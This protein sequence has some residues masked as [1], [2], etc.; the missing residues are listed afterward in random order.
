MVRAVD[1]VTDGRIDWETA[2]AGGA[3]AA[4][5]LPPLPAS[6][7]DSIRRNKIAIKGP[8]STPI[9]KGLRTVNVA[10]RQEL[11]LYASVRPVRTL[12]GVNVP[13]PRRRSGGGAR[14]HRGPVLRAGARRRARRGRGLRDRHPRA[15]PSASCAS[16]SSGPPRRARRVSRSATRRR[17]AALRRPVPRL[18]RDGGRRVSLPRVRG[19]RHRQPC[20]CELA[21]DP[22]RYDVLVMGNLFGDVLSDLCA[23]LVG[24]LGRGAGREHRRRA[25]PCSRRCTAPRPNIAGK[26]TG[27]PDRADPLG[28]ADAASTSAS[29]DAAV[30]I[31]AWRRDAAAGRPA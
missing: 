29:C 27:Q 5:D 10:L 9:G 18:A 28:G 23:G 26:G 12:P 6:T 13:L 8:L 24:G 16:P 25:T 30:E 20:A 31:A 15:P 3:A 17:D 1:V 11:D 22:S 19:A 14:E 7:L 21:L 4:Q 2:I